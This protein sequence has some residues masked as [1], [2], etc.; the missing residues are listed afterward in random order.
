MRKILF[1]LILISSTNIIYA[2]IP[3]KYLSLKNN[4][5][6]VRYG[7]GFNYPIKY[8]YKKKY[9][10]IKIIDQKENFRKIIDLKKNSGWIHISQLTRQNSLIILENKILFKNPS[11]FSKPIV[12]LKEGRLLIITKCKYNWCKVKTGNFKGWVRVENSWGLN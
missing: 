6:N 11:I 9:L 5:V 2:E 12:K 8:V 3:E 1:L 10:P 4:I 7:P